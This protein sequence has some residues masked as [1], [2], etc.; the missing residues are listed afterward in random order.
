M[1]LKPPRPNP[2]SEFSSY[3]YNIS[4]YLI[5]PETY[6]QYAT[7][8]PN[9][10]NDWQ[11]L[12]QSGGIPGQTVYENNG[13]SSFSGQTPRAPGF[14]LDYYIDN[15]KIFTN[16]NFKVTSSAT[17]SFKF[18]F[19]IVEPNGFKFPTDLVKAVR[20]MQQ[21]SGLYRSDHISES[22]VALQAYFLLV[23]R[24]YGYDK[25]GNI[26]KNTSTQDPTVT[27]SSAALERAWPIL[28][29]GFNFKLNDRAIVY[30]VDATL[31]PELLAMGRLRGT[32]GSEVNISGTTV[33]EMLTSLTDALNAQQK[34]LVDSKK[35]TV[36]DKYIINFAPNS[37][38]DTAKMIDLKTAYN[39]TTPMATVTK[40]D[41]SNVRT[42]SQAN[43]VEFVK[44]TIAVNNQ[45][46]I[47]VIDQIITQSS[48]VYDTLSYLIKEETQPVTGNPI[49]DP[50][51]TNSDSGKN[52][53]KW[54]MVTPS[55][56][57][58]NADPQRGNINSTEITF[59]IQPHNIP[60]IRGLNIGKAGE[61]PGPYKRYQHTYLSG[62]GK[63]ILSFEQNYNLL[64][65]NL[66][67][68]NISSTISPNNDLTAAAGIGS[69]DVNSQGRVGDWFGKSISPIKSYLYGPATQ[70][71]SKIVIL[72]DPD[73][74]ITCTARGFDV[75]TNPYYGED[76]WSINPT[77]GQIFVEIDFRDASD[78]DTDIGL[79]NVAK[80]DDIFFYNYPPEL[81]IKGMA[82]NV[83]QI[84]STFSKGQFTQEMKFSVPNFANQKSAATSATS[85]TASAGIGNMNSASLNPANGSSATTIPSGATAPEANN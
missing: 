83:W 2:L 24:F 4:L 11:L 52:P 47:N 62:T 35:Y 8:G 43:T 21:S 63:E 19:Q 32:V 27:D 85:T 67:A 71:T 72:G 1:A 56:K 22:V 49:T 44:K 37:N 10:P 55:I 46:I 26:V 38:I 7:G 70:M 65:H 54:F 75:L 57:L 45:P 42:S 15:L 51:I 59:T 36:A 34:V 18:N 60:D 23:V 53:L 41:Q 20:K 80:D 50:S 12:V 29:S 17:N 31:V 6:N 79:L 64:F 68:E 3:T 13:A 74:L 81:G 9:T 28:I 30:N 78:Y 76:G 25:D 48:Y 16:T 33:G 39:K 84:T 58:G 73:Y 40:P 82:L 5:N 61:Y 69:A 66:M 14:E 77:T